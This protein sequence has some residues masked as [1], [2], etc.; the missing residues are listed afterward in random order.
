VLLG[1][2]HRAA[3][4]GEVLDFDLCQSLFLA[5]VR[6]LRRLLED[7]EHGGAP[8]HGPAASTRSEP[9]PDWVVEETVM[10]LEQI[11]EVYDVLLT[12]A[13]TYE[14]AD[15][16]V[17]GLLRLY[18]LQVLA[19]AVG[20]TNITAK[21]LMELLSNNVH[22][23]VSVVTFVL[24]TRDAP[25]AL[26]ELASRCL[27]QL[28]TA[29]CIFSED[30]QTNETGISSLTEQLQKHTNGMIQAIVQFDAV[31]AFG[32]CICQHQE[33]HFRTDILVKAFL[34]MIHNSLLSAA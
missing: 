9:S 29:N 28:T 16:G 3:D 26:Q 1:C 18:M 22:S 21:S 34:G 31:D 13:E 23:A 5:V 33:S 11:N 20:Y 25:F 8:F 27:V 2:T 4:A 19:M 12:W 24:R 32:R 14:W 10:F 30:P 15:P 6:I 17:T 7:P